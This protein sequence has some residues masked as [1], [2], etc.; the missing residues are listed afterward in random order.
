MPDNVVEIPAQSGAWVEVPA[1]SIIRIIDVEGAKVADMFAVC[2]DDHDEWL[3]VANTRGVN[4]SLVPPV[5][6]RFVGTRYRTMF[7]F[8]RDDSPR[9]HDALFS[10]CDPIMYRL[11]GCADD[12]PSCAANFRRAAAGFGWKP[13]V[14]PGPMNFFQRTP[15]DSDGTMS[16]LPAASKAG[17]SVSLRA[18][19]DVLAIV[20]ACSMDLKDINGARCTPI[21]LEVSRA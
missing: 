9:Y 2:A 13:P 20:T 4:W 11:L 12:H 19:T 14:V 16:T 10:A 5:G 1:G 15:V 7:T 21:R 17:D 3:S 6:G 8:A 18:E